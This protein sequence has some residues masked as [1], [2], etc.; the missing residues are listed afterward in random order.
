MNL[1]RKYFGIKTWII[2]AAILAVE[3]IYYVIYERFIVTEDVVYESLAGNMSIEQIARGLA[4]METFNFLYFL[5]VIASAILVIFAISFSVNIGILV[6]K[7]KVTFAKV[8]DVVAKAYIAFSIARLANLFILGRMQIVTFDDLL[9]APKLS[10]VDLM[11]RVGRP[12]WMLYAFDRV[13]VFQILFILLLAFG[14]KPILNKS[15]GKSTLFVLG[16]YGLALLIWVSFASY[17][18]YSDF[19]DKVV[20][21]VDQ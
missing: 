6:K 14:L 18:L 10:L 8:F 5:I 9:L 3:I 7:L 13:N 2:V 1:L 12:T 20:L 17:M 15:M 11:G 16:T 19:L 21:G 4:E